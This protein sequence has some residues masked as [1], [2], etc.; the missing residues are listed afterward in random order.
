MALRL[1]DRGEQLEAV[2]SSSAVRALGI[3]EV[4]SNTLA[5]SLAV[6]PELYTFSAKGLYQQLK[7]L[8]DHYQRLAVVSH[9][10]AITDVTIQLLGNVT[11]NLPTSGIVAIDCDIDH[12]HKLSPQHCRMDYIDFPKNPFFKNQ[13]LEP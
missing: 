3:A 6:E 10:P 9:N 5:I 2:I 1:L 7:A 4:I 12:W 8:P 13:E 11:D